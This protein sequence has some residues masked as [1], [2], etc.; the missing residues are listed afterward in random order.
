MLLGHMLVE[1]LR[2]TERT[3]STAR[4]FIVKRAFVTG[5]VFS[6]G[7]YYLERFATSGTGQVLLCWSWAMFCLQV[8]YQ[9]L[10]GHI[11]KVAGLAPMTFV[12]SA[13]FLMQF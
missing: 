1:P 7:L 6:H 12:L 8:M 10:L 4:N 11:T 5:H 2:E 13:G 9:S 3:R